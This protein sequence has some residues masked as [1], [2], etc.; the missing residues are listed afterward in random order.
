MPEAFQAAANYLNEVG[1]K[2]EHASMKTGTFFAQWTAMRND[3]SV[4][5]LF[6][7]SM[8]RHYTDKNPLTTLQGHFDIHGNTL[9]DPALDA[10]VNEALRT[11]HPKAHEEVLKKLYRYMHEQLPLIDLYAQ[12]EFHGL[13]PRVDWSFSP[14]NPT[15][16]EYIQWRPGYP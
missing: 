16:M 3:R 15:H 5:T 1:M 2:V 6:P 7:M 12:I 4:T 13:G 10:I 11:A 8:V 14:G 9:A